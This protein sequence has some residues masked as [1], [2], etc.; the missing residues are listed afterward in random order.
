MKVY[1]L[2]FVSWDDARFGGV[3]STKEAA[4]ARGEEMEEWATEYGLD[5]YVIESEIDVPN[6][7]LD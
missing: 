2:M 5:F 1:T 4:T 7:N 6:V 3:F